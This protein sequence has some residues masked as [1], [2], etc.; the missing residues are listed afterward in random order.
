MPFGVGRL[1]VPPPPPPPPV[2]FS[3]QIEPIFQTVRCIPGAWVLGGASAWPEV[4][5]AVG[6]FH[7]HLVPRCLRVD[8]QP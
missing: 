2:P 7:C 8:E 3:F 4:R 5:W 1:S 6:V